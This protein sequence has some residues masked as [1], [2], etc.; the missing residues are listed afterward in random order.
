MKAV[1][2]IFLSHEILNINI[3]RSLNE[4]P[5][6]WDKLVNGKV[7]V[8]S[9]NIARLGPHMEDLRI[10]PTLLK[11]DVIHLCETW[12]HPNQEGAAQFQLEGFTTHFVSVGNGRGLATY[13]RGAFMH[14]EDRVDENWQITKFSS[15]AIDSIHIYRCIGMY[16]N[17]IVNCQLNYNCQYLTKMSIMRYPPTGQPLEVRSSW[18]ITWSK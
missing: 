9:L 12:I 8:A 5:G 18:W 2:H 13:T 4:N 6:D 11:A 17:Y 15:D 10:D 1:S 16:L 3:L 14:Q 7:R